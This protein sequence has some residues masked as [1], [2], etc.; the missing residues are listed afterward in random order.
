MFRK[1]KYCNPEVINKFKPDSLY[2]LSPK[3]SKGSNNTKFT[4]RATEYSYD[5]LKWEKIPVSLSAV[6][7]R[8]TK[9]CIALKLKSLKA[10]DEWIDLDDY[11]QI[12]GENNVKITQFTSTQCI[13]PFS[14]QSE[15]LR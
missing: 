10:V 9:G 6:I 3:S 12:D 13:I 15:P 1:T 14:E 7:G 2:L 4:Q 8:L 11:V 5:N